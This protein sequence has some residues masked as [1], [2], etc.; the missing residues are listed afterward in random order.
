M[1]KKKL[2]S[3]YGKGGKMSMKEILK[4]LRDETDRF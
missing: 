3:M 1:K 4:D 2:K